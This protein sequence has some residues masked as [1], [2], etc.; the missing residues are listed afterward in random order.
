MGV[1][2]GA[3]S[4][5]HHA[6]LAH[7]DTRGPHKVAQSRPFYRHSG[8]EHDITT[9]QSETPWAYSS[10][11]LVSV[12]PEVDSWESGRFLLEFLYSVGSE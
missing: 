7:V 6:G 4:R 10:P 1:G 11:G 12:V 8:M 2:W 3:V 5:S 9:S